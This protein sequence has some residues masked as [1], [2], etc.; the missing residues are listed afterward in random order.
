MASAMGVC[1]IPTV[2]WEQRTE[3]VGALLHGFTRIWGTGLLVPPGPPRASGCLVP[4]IVF[5]VCSG[6]VPVSCLAPAK[7]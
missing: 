2:F 7:C 4:F 1:L 6:L 5:L 3:A